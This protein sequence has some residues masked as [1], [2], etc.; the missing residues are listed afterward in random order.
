MS[1]YQKFKK[2]V[3]YLIKNQKTLLKCALNVTV[4]FPDTDTR[5]KIKHGRISEQSNYQ[6]CNFITFFIRLLNH[7]RVSR[8]FR[9]VN[10]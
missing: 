5:K 8:V 6:V 4:I 10:A 7:H 3:N 2:K 1:N 9:I